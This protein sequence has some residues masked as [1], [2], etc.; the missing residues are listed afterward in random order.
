MSTAVGGPRLDLDARTR[1]MNDDN[2]DGGRRLRYAIIGAGMGGL[3]AAIKL[4]EAG[5]TDY[6]IYEKGDG[7][8]GT[9]RENRYPGLTCD[10]AS[11]MYT[12]TF[13]PNPGWSRYYARGPE[14]RE[15]FQRVA[16]E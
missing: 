15:Y 12:Y 10:V 5:D 11:H 7:V 4:N 1:I 16:D 14:I 6:T 13:A 9:W 3:L 8:G 2:P